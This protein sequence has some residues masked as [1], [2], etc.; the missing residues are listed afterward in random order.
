MKRTVYTCDRCQ[1]PLSDELEGIARPHI[2]LNLSMCGSVAKH[3]H[4]MRWEYKK[5]FGHKVV[6]FC[7]TSCLKDFVDAAIKQD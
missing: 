4:L 5:C 1:A 7:S 6:Q 2:N 3:K